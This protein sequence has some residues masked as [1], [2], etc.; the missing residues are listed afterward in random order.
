MNT[1][2]QLVHEVEA[3]GGTIAVA[4]DKLKLAAPAPLPPRV[5]PK[6]GPV[7]GPVHNPQQ[8]TCAYINRDRRGKL[9]AMKH[10][11][12]KAA[13]VIMVL[14]MPIPAFA[15]SQENGQDPREMIEGAAEMMLQALELMLNAIP[16]Y[17]APEVL[18]NGDIIIRRKPQKRKQP[19]PEKDTTVDRDKT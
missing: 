6:R 8:Q 19:S 9:V 13:V 2:L 1:A 4:G 17:E 12:F 14:S 11:L 7:K 18:E 16:Q 3:A 5:L 10:N 15:H